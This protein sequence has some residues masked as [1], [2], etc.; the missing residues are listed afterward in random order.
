MTVK[1][2]TPSQKACQVSRPPSKLVLSNSP[3]TSHVETHLYLPPHPPTISLTQR[4][5]AQMIATQCRM[6]SARRMRTMK[7][8]TSSDPGIEEYV[9]FL[10]SD[11]SSPT[12]RSQRLCGNELLDT[13]SDSGLNDAEDFEPMSAATRRAAEAKMRQRDRMERGGRRGMRAA[14]RSHAPNFFDSDDAS[15]GD[16]ATRDCS[17]EHARVRGGSMMSGETS[18]IW[19]VSKTCVFFFLLCAISLIR[20][21]RRFLWN[22]SAISKRNRSSSGSLMIVFGGPSSS[23]SVSS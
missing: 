5:K 9:L 8:R 19:K 13:Y 23:I 16:D 17:L 12:T 3:T 15:V 18:M 4:E 11:S 10:Q 22:S 14:N 1:R 7:A 6:L 20:W 21:S 2:N